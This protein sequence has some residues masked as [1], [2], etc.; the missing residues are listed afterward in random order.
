MVLLV[1]GSSCVAEMSNGLEL[2]FM[3]SPLITRHA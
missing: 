1:L 3:I 2:A